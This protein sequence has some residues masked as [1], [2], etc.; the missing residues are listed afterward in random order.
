[1]PNDRKQPMDQDVAPDRQDRERAKP[2]DDAWQKDEDRVTEASDESFPASDAP[3]WIGGSASPNE[4][5]E[6]EKQARTGA[7]GE[8]GRREVI[9]RGGRAS[10][11]ICGSI[12]VRIVPTGASGYVLGARVRAFAHQRF[13]D[14]LS[15]VASLWSSF[16]LRS[17][18]LAS[19]LSQPSGGCL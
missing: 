2:G 16:A 1:M 12:V 17:A 3:A 5:E 6:G 7:R 11:R 4:H 8:G 18:S 14:F 10:R 13:A 19:A 15:A 9:V